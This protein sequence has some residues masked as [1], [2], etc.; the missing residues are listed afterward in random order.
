MAGQVS[1]FRLRK[2]A[3][4]PAWQRDAAPGAAFQPLFCCLGAIDGVILQLS[5]RR[6]FHASTALLPRLQ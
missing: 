4:R 5:P 3:P 2:T 1:C 6:N